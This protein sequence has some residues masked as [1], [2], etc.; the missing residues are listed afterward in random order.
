[1]LLIVFY[2]LF[3][4]WVKIIPTIDINNIQ[5]ACKVEEDSS[6]L[7]E[8]FKDWDNYKYGYTF[9]IELLSD[10]PIIGDDYYTEIY[11]IIKDFPNNLIWFKEEMSKGIRRGMTYKY[12]NYT[13][14]DLY[15]K[16]LIT[17][18]EKD[19]GLERYYKEGFTFSEDVFPVNMRLLSISE[20]ELD[21]TKGYLVLSYY[22][23]NRGK[24]FKN[25]R[26]IPMNIDN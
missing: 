2:Y 7:N 15:D 13:L 14:E 25:I 21:F 23:K 20:E 9:S 10:R 18:E 4:S 1:M 12:F 16:G 26:A 5:I 24:I 3:Y 11:I 22:E 19:N 17:F 8:Y 6:I